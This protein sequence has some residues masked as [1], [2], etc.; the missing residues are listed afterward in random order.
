MPN[1]DYYGYLQKQKVSGQ[2]TPAEQLNLDMIEKANAAKAGISSLW[3]SATKAASNLAQDVG[4][5][6][7]A[8]LSNP[9]LGS[10][11]IELEK[12]A[13]MRALERMRNQNNGNNF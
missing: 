1:S 7:Q 10:A 3:G 5:T 4:D 6:A 8:K 13:K 12:Q 2:I 9:E 11:D